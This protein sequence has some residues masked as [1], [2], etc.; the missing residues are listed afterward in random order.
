MYPVEVAFEATLENEFG[1]SIPEY[2]WCK[3]ATASM[4][5]IPEELVLSDMHFCKNCG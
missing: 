1:A 5:L 3:P 2:I 4:K